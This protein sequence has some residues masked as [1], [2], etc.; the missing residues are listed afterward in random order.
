[1]KKV[2]LITGG[3][4]GI[5]QRAAQRAL[6]AGDSVAVLDLSASGFEPLGASKQLLRLTA[7]VT[8]AGAVEKAVEEAESVLG[9]IDRVINAAAI[10][11][12][13]LLME[14]RKDLIHRIMEIN[15]GGLVNIARAVLPG[16]LERRRGEFVS[17]SSSAGHIPLIYM[18]AYD[19]SK[20]AVNAFTEVL[21][22][23]N[24]GSGVKFC[25]VCPPPVATPL[26]NQAKDTVW[27]RMF[28]QADA[29]TADDVLD[30]TERALARGEFWV[31]PGPLTR[32][33]V[34]ARRL[35]PNMLWKRVHQVEGR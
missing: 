19:A 32:W 28:D 26:L 14:Q 15:Y 29:I 11:P 33:Y 3:G 31:F 2:V 34:R 27:P 22:H 30:A 7:D 24:R 23:E 4:S 8:D 5:G 21:F 35:T 10:M 1:M 18:G 17:F 13:G 16:M 9:P 25:C 6:A 12:L 20:A